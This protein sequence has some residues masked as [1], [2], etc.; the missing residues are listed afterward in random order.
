MP[1]ES[2]QKLSHYRLIEKIGEG[3]MGVV[4]KAEDTVLGRT[5]AIKVLPAEA[6]RDE[7]RR[8]MLLDEA[9]LAS[10]VSAA[11]IVQIHEFGREGDL[12]FIVMEY[13][14]GKPLS[15][16]LHG[17]PLPPEKVASL[18]VQISQALS[19]AHHKG[20]LHRDLKPG[21]ILVTSDGDVKV[22]DFGLAAL[23][24]REGSGPESQLDTRVSMGS[25]ADRKI[26][27][28]IPYMSPEQL[29]GKKLDARSDIFSLGVVLYEMTTGQRPFQGPTS[30]DVAAEVRRAR[31][32]PPHEIVPNVPLDLHRIIEKTLAPRAA[33]RYQTM[34]DLAVDLRRL[35]RD[36]ESGSSPSYLDL[37]R[38]G[39]P[40]RRGKALE[41][42]A[43]AGAFLAFAAIIWLI[44]NFA[45]LSGDPK[46]LIVLPMQVR[47][48]T[49]GADYVGQAF[50]ESLAVNLAQFEGLTVLPVPEQ[51]SLLENRRQEPKRFAEESGAGRLLTGSITRSANRVQASLSLLSTAENRILW[52][53]QGEAAEE[54]LARLAS[55]LA[56]QAAEAMG[57]AAPK[58][59]D[60]TLNLTGGFAMAASPLSGVALGAL[61]RRE[62]LEA[63]NATEKLVAAFP[64]DL[65]AFALRAQA[66]MDQIRAMGAAP[67]TVA[68]LEETMARMESLDP[69]NP[70]TTQARGRLVTF[71]GSGTG[72]RMIVGHPAA[73]GNASE[74]I[75]ILGGLLER[76]DLAPAL[77]VEILRSRAWPL[78]NAGE[79]AK[80]MA[81][82]EEALRHDPTNA[83]IH[84]DLG[85]ILHEAGRHEE[86]VL[87][88]RRAVA[89]EPSDWSH[90]HHLARAL[91]GAGMI[92]ESLTAARR[93]CEMSHL[94]QPCAMVAGQLQ[95]LDR[96]EEAQAAAEAAA[97]LPE[98]RPG[99]YNLACYW[100]LAGEK[101]RAITWLRKSIQ[102]GAVAAW[103]AN[104]PDLE[105]LH[106]D[107][108]FEALVAEVRRRSAAQDQA[109]AITSNPGP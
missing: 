106:G 92:E 82:L 5:V 30:T 27:G 68:R 108:E 3:G 78:R 1:G 33:E 52:G 48:Q 55:T 73:G 64:E 87:H 53:T 45:G 83:G 76:K 91:R 25:P 11:H 36:L 75:R 62:T 12:D 24:T 4:W 17:R 60:A 37:E 58:L 39:A 43:V 59:Y 98:S 80:A 72:G 19:K 20:L 16:I 69:R 88:A 104:D 18:G 107:P 67:E 79:M 100:A 66:L 103:M 109:A 89:L 93:S 50:A 56:G 14:E 51:G 94:Q 47:G 61:R 95:I 74:A 10:S 84:S 40:F 81:T 23:F 63:V 49:E 54:D 35:G 57:L 105:S 38:K 46:T 13:V 41:L 32:R 29:D 90:Y 28:T 101:A 44:Y 2:G 15:A 85:A 65:D 7:Q 97:L 71:A 77:R 86:A 8:K 21:N 99:T 102:G 9:R 42:A 6:A 70:Y 96:R 26:A 22:L 34:D 31:P